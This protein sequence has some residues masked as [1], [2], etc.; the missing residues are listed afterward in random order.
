MRR[1][2]I[3]AAMPQRFD[4]TNLRRHRQAHIDKGTHE[5]LSPLVREISSS[6]GTQFCI[7]ETKPQRHG[8]ISMPNAECSPLR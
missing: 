3:N 4:K 8:T 5:Y 6:I 1:V 7:S 2:A